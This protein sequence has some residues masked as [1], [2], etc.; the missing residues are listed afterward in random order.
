MLVG[1]YST[2]RVWALWPFG[3]LA[4]WPFTANLGG[5][6]SIDINFLAHTKNGVAIPRGL[7]FISYAYLE[8]KPE[9][10]V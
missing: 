7:G 5:D 3:P 10:V 8:I 1:G 4:L 9:P 6:F 2:L